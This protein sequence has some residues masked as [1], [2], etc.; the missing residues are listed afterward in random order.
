ME[1]AEAA[2]DTV[3]GRRNGGDTAPTTLIRA[4]PTRMRRGAQMLEFALMLPIVLFMLTFML[5]MGHMILLSGAL[6]DSVG[7]AARAGAQVGGAGANETGPS[8]RALDQALNDA[9]G[10]DA[11]GLS[12]YIIDSGSR[13]ATTGDDRY[14]TI[15]VRYPV[16][17]ITPGI[18]SL[19][20]IIDGERRG[21]EGAWTL[22][23]TAVS[24]CEIVLP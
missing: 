11:D 7:V 17:F 5:D 16:A 23:A 24:R 3:G 19:L 20:G 8:R 2:G 1:M 21:P 10:L 12:R 9:P 13:C 6:Q 18:T 14:I 15:D 4:D 22:G